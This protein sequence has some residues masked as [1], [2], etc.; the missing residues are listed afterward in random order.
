MKILITIVLLIMIFIILFY[1]RVEHLEEDLKQ[2]NKIVVKNRIR[3]LIFERFIY[4][5]KSNNVRTHFC[6]DDNNCA[7]EVL[8]KK[9][10][11]LKVKNKEADD[12]QEQCEP[13]LKYFQSE[14][15]Y[16]M[17]IKSFERMLDN[18][19]IAKFDEVCNETKL[20]E[21]R[22]LLFDTLFNLLKNNGILDISPNTDEPSF[23]DL[24]EY[25]GEYNKDLIDDEV[26]VKIDIP[27]NLFNFE[28]FTAQSI[29][30]NKLMKELEMYLK[31]IHLKIQEIELEMQRNG[32]HKKELYYTH[33]INHTLYKK[34]DNNHLNKIKDDI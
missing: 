15:R 30:Y 16:E 17:G 20:D 8:Y 18:C 14:D 28:S 5:I 31:I 1:Q 2:P 9:Y 10:E 32:D 29:Y 13:F 33:K 7:L 26:D 3:E 11:T 23:D 24:V 27:K 22:K 25:G 19:Y 12:K 6:K 21:I 4:L 34:S